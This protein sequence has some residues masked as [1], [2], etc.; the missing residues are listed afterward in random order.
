MGYNKPKLIIIAK[1][2]FYYVKHNEAKKLVCKLHI[3]YMRPYA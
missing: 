2:L 3:K 1:T